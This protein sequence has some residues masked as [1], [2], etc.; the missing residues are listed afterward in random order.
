MDSVYRGNDVEVPR[1]PPDREDKAYTNRSYR[2]VYI[3]DNIKG[4]D[5]FAVSFSATSSAMTPLAYSEIINFS[6]RSIKKNQHSNINI[7]RTSEAERGSLP[8]R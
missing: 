4:S 2:F 1:L 6:L 8:A 5:Q 3:H 7:P